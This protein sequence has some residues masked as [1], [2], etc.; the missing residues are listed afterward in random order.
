MINPLTILRRTGLVLKRAAREYMEDGGIAFAAGLAFYMLFSLAPLVILLVWGTGLI[1]PD[2][3]AALIER[4]ERAMGQVGGAAVDAI[5]RSA[6]EHAWSGTVSAAVGFAA[7]LFGA[8][9]IWAHMQDALDHIWGIKVKPRQALWGWVRKR[10]MGLVMMLIIV[11]L[12]IASAIAASVLDF[13]FPAQST[14]WPVLEWVLSF[15]VYFVLF[16]LIYRIL[17]DVTIA[18]RDAWLGAAVTTVLLLIGKYAA[19]WYLSYSDIG[20]AY[21]AAGSLV[22][23]LVFIYYCAMIVFFGAEVT[24]VYTRRFGHGMRPEREVGAEME[25]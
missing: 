14:L 7:L 10:L 3:R 16:T 8:T 18:W 9:A 12:F 15:A 19:G 22:A 1:D 21:G 5:L 4:V 17:P 11:G 2:T 25:N 13:I 20:S 6:R 23:M 24:Q